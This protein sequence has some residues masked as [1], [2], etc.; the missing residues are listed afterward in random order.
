MA[1][2]EVPVRS[3]AAVAAE[4]DLGVETMMVVEEGISVEWCRRQWRRPA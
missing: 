2:I 1:A 3:R 4:E